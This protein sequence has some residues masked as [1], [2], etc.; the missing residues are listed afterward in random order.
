MCCHEE[1]YIYDEHVNSFL[2]KMFEIEWSTL[3]V[4]VKTIDSQRRSKYKLNTLGDT[5]Q[6]NELFEE[7]SEAKNRM[8]SL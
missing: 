7:K 4:N 8:L 3:L 6:Q 5:T 1:K 2:R